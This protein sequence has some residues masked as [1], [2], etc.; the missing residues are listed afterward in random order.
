MYMDHSLPSSRYG[1]LRQTGFAAIAAATLVALPSQGVLGHQLVDRGTFR[2]VIEGI[3]AGTEAFTIQRS[4][5]GDAQIT[6]AKG[7][8]TMRD[9][10]R[11]TTLLS[12]QG[13]SLALTRYE[14]V[15]SGTDTL[16][17]RLF[18]A[19]SRIEVRTVAPWGEEVREYRARPSTAIF[20]DGVAHHYFV[21][22]L[23]LEREDAGT[24]HAV[25]PLSEREE[26]VAGAEI[27]PETIQVDGESVE[28]MRV[29]VGGG[30]RARSA[31]F[32]GSGRLVRVELPGMGFVAQ[33]VSGG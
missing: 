31:W 32:D 18:R 2:L 8:V 1:L 6:L 27:R 9:G 4:G 17:I 13:P 26:A 29:L 19:G 5:T 7:T 20:D 24:L 3:E 25:A 11:L 30:D 33:R 15:I 12:V 14:A 10:R 21:L 23:L 22:G 16:A 28:V